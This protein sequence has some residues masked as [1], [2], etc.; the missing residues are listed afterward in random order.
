MEIDHFLGYFRM[1]KMAE[2]L[3]LKPLSDIPYI[4]FRKQSQKSRKCDNNG[5]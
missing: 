2:K 3:D 1:E 4:I 5:S